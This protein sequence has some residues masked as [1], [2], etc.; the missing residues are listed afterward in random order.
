L[1]TEKQAF[2]LKKSGFGFIHLYKNKLVSKLN[3]F[4]MNNKQLSVFNNQI[5]FKNT[6]HKKLGKT[7]SVDYSAG[8]SETRNGPDIDEALHLKEMKKINTL[9]EKK[10]KEQSKKMSEVVAT[11]AKF[12]SIIAHDLRS[13]FSSII[14]VLELLKDSFHEYNEKEIDK[15]LRMASNSANGMLA[16]LDNLLSWTAAQNKAAHIN[17]VKI[18]LHE[19]MVEE[20]DN[21][22][23]TATHKLI[24]INQDI[25]SGILVSADL[26]MVK[27]IIR[28]LLNNAIKYSFIGGEIEIKAKREKEFVE[29]TIEDHGI[30]ITNKAKKELLKRDEIHST[31]GTNN[32]NGTGLGLILCKDFV[33]K[34]GGNLLIDSEPGKGTKIRFTL[35]GSV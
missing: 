26:Q 25:A 23:T 12:L 6:G 19:L 16:L 10:L 11:N 18:E 35:P 28:N 34:H 22:I 27:T 3:T 14:G 5:S 17:P 31:R 20:I 24:T 33:E 32:E 4:I 13:P 8:N 2:W 1:H 30:G 21:M 29:I 15:Y 7:M 9:L